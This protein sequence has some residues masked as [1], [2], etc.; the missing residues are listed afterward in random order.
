V[1]VIPISI[2]IEIV[3][4]KCLI[5]LAFHRF[6]STNSIKVLGGAIVRLRKNKQLLLTRD[7]IMDMLL[8]PFKS[9]KA[10]TLTFKMI[11]KRCQAYELAI[12]TAVWAM[13][14]LFAMGW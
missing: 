13:V 3:L 11:E 2:Q 10:A 7:E 14:Q 5:L 6:R 12:A 9:H 4:G 1:V 8:N